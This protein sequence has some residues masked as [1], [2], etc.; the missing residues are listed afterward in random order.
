MQRIQ[1]TIISLA[2]LFMSAALSGQTFIGAG[3][4][5]GITISSSSQ[6]GEASADNTLNGSGMN[7]ELMAASRFLTQATLG[8]DMNDVERAASLQPE[9]WIDE[10]MT[11]D[12]NLLTPMVE[13]IWDEIYG[14]NV[15]FYIELYEEENPGAPITQEV[16]DAIDQEIFGPWG[17]DFNYAWFESALTNDDQLRQRVAWAMSQ[18]FVIS[19]NSSLGNHAYSLSGFYD[20]LLEHAFGNYRDLMEDV[21]LSPAMGLYLSHYNNPREIPSEN[22]HPDENYAREI[23]Q[24]FS[25]GLYELNNDGTRKLDADGRYIPTYNNNDIKELAKVF[26]GLG[27]GAVRE[28][29]WVDTPFFG[30]DWYL[31]EEQ[32]PMQMFQQFHEPGEKVLL[33]RHV[34]PEGQPGMQDIEETLDFLFEHPNVGPFISRQLIQR[35]VKSNPSPAYIDRVATVFNDNG[36]GVRGD[37]GAVVKALLLD[38]EAR[39][40]TEMLAPD[41]GQLLEPMIRRLKL[42][43]AFPLTC[44]RDGQ[45]V[46]DGDTLDRVPCEELRYW[47]NGINMNR[48]QRQSPLGAPSVFNFYLPDH[49]PVG[50]FASDGLFGPEFKI[51]DSTTAL[52]YVNSLHITFFWDVYGFSWEGEVKPEIG[53]LSIVTDE[54]Q[55]LIDDPEALYNYLDIVLTRGMLTDET[56]AELRS[57]VDEQPDWVD[58]YSKVRGVLYLLGLSP[59]FTILK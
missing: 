52:N 48:S 55:E 18:I 30:M 26:T 37:F 49:Q 46:V 7:A 9:A 10:Q 13:T 36:Q 50:D 20:H 16:L 32:E 43:K 29:P 44:Y 54:V 45:Q 24:L 25:I 22:L 59:D 39:S 6:E 38:D 56:R 15:D 2:L 42:G 19:M 34:I 12:P 23:M 11:M 8:Y 21:T 40:C 53:Y 1:L 5:E 14:W 33:G 35:L 57:F 31:A 4:D 51:H 17:V 47:I 41:N 3:N 27:A 58:D 28:N